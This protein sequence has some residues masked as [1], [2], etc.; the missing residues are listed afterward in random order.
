MRPAGARRR[1]GAWSDRLWWRA[2]T[3]RTEHTRQPR[4]S[5]LPDLPHERATAANHAW[6]RLVRAL[7][8][9]AHESGRLLGRRR[10]R[11][12]V[13]RV[14]G[15]VGDAQPLEPPDLPGVSGDLGRRD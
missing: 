3:R 15:V 5:D 12:A 7:Q 14:P 4:Q 9:A 1:A 13:R 8:L 6:Q 2:P 11:G 10:W